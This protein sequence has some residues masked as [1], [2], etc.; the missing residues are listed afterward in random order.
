MSRTSEQ[1]RYQDWEISQE[2]CQ[3][4]KQEQN[5]YQSRKQ[6]QNQTTYQNRNQRQN[7][8]PDKCRNNTKDER[9]I[10]RRR[11]RRLYLP[12]ICLATAAVLLCGSVLLTRIL[13]ENASSGSLTF[14]LREHLPESANRIFNP[15]EKNREGMENDSAD[16][17][18]RDRNLS[19]G[20]INS[21]D[22]DSPSARSI[23]FNDTNSPSAGNGNSN[24]SATDSGSSNDTDSLN[25]GNGNS[26]ERNA[27]SIN[28]N[29]TDVLSNGSDNSNDTATGNLSAGTD[30]P[31]G[32]DEI[33]A[34]DEAAET[35]A[36][37]YLLLVNRSHPLPD[38][39]QDSLELTELDNGQSVDSRIYPSL[40]AMFDAMRGDGVYPVV[41][42]G[43]RTAEKQQS[44][45]DEKIA[46][47]KAEGYSDADARKEAE[48]WVAVPGASEHQ[49][50]S[51][52]DI[53]A[54]GIHSAGYE[55][56]EWLDAHA[57]EYGFIRRYPPDKA[58]ITG[59]SSEPWHYRY[60]GTDAA[61][62]IHRRGICLE[63]YLGETE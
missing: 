28:S 36:P 51:A 3:G 25:T 31:D 8:N 44:L 17:N 48:T 35:G 19:D 26:N 62:E 10:T 12:A 30:T 49:L 54:D 29:D 23:N 22:T 63:E 14:F 21:N 18:S 7:Q 58:E 57:H 52:V 6:R 34:P 47:L 5:P 43:F 50:G 24:S 53:N 40:Q 4:R 56:Y 46:S 2:P 11:R 45:M 55:V 37:W 61:A 27:G 60:V 15:N 20:S 1:G 13:P 59:I 42:S 39:Y 38:G 33:A 9:K 16:S 41:A 32:T